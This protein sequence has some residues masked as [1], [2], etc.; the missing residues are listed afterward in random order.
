MKKYVL[1]IF[2]FFLSM[3]LFPKLAHAEQLIII[4]KTT[5]QLAFYEDGILIETLPVAT[6]RTSDLTP[7]GKFKVI[8]MYRNMPY[9]KK[10]IPGGDPR[11]PLG[12]RW[13]GLNVPGTGG[14]TYGIHG[15]NAEYTIGS[16]ASSG[17]VRM[18]NNDVR[19]LYSRVD[20]G[21]DVIITNT[22]ATFE[23]IAAQNQFTLAQKE[24]V[25]E[26]I[27]LTK[28]VQTYSSPSKYSLDTG[29]LQPRKVQIVEKQGKWMHAM[30]EG[31]NY[32]FK[33]MD[34]ST[35]DLKKYSV[36]FSVNKSLF[37]FLSPNEESPL[38]K[39][40]SPHYVLSD[41][42]INGWYHISYSSFVDGWVK[43]SSEL[44]VHWSTYPSFT[45]SLFSKHT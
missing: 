9:Y 33:T 43:P 36:L 1:G 37:L 38:I 29:I 30:I 31:N 6:G 16:H 45:T 32:W 35:G 23:Q 8:K 39:T 24:E 11:N 12:D 41:E 18:R 22:Y 40:I 5:N 3:F 4:K 13:I 10:N 25:N 42:S 34:Y 14:F 44:K 28:A 2:V 7:E 15:T 26:T 17:C 21:A 27:T 20:V 19:R